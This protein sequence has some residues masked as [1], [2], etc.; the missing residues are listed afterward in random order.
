MRVTFF[1][2]LAEWI[3]RSVD[4]ELP[5]H[6]MSIG[7]LRVLIGDRFPHARDEMLNGK[8]R[9]CVGDLLVDDGFLVGR[10]HIVEFLPPVSGG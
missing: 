1:G 9:A 10:E 7:D 3:G 6:T 8:V 4:M 2:K 5:E